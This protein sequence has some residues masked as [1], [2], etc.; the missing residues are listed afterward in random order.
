MNWTDIGKIKQL[1]L[2]QSFMEKNNTDKEIN[3][4]YI[5]SFGRGSG[6]SI[7]PIPT[8]SCKNC[9]FCGTDELFRVCHRTNPPHFLQPIV[10]GCYAGEQSVVCGIDLAKSPDM[11]GYIGGISFAEETGNSIRR[12]SKA[13]NEMEE[14]K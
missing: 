11:T 4:T 10:V 2:Y 12:I 9:R 14:E 7:I 13:L 6:K 5:S 3:S 1:S 8:T